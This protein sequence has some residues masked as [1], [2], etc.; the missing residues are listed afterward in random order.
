[1]N[2]YLYIPPLSSHPPSCFKGLIHGEL[3]RYYRQNN[4]DD[5]IDIMVKFINRLLERG[6]TIENLT[7][8]PLFYKLLPN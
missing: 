6:Y 2:L 4:K 5:F 3:Q 1:M 7:P 8:P